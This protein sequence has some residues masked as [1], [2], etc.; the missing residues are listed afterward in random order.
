MADA[1]REAISALTKAVM[2]VGEGARGFVVD[3]DACGNRGVITAGRIPCGMSGSPIVSMDGRAIGLI[4]IGTINPILV[5]ARSLPPLEGPLGLSHRRPS[6]P[7]KL[8]NLGARR[9]ASPRPQTE[10]DC[11]GEP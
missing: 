4:S 3:L 5:D 9:P 8:Q 10:N 1:K 6:N 2:R 11:L 7:Q